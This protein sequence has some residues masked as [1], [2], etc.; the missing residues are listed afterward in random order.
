MKGGHSND[1]IYYSTDYSDYI[2]GIYRTG[3]QCNWCGIYHRI[4]RCDC[5]CS[6]NSI[7][8]EM[9]AKKET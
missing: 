8:Y 2:G 1:T 5:M 4:C 9:A 7:S 6:L 3:H